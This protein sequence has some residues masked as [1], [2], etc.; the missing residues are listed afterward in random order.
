MREDEAWAARLKLHLM[1]DI[2][3][4]RQPMNILY[5]GSSDWAKLYGF[6]CTLQVVPKIKTRLSVCLKA[7]RS[8]DTVLNLQQKSAK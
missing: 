1:Q 4:H 2:M 7:D 8:F 3:R 6:T 5:R